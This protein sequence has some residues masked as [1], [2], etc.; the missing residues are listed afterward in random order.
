MFQGW[1][2]FI[3]KSYNSKFIKKSYNSIYQ[4][5]FVQI[6]QEEFS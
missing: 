5:I 6:I 1:Q 4:S 3:K 2:T